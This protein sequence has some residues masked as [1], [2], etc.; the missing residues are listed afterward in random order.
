MGISVAT[1][2][3]MGVVGCVA[4][5][6]VGV[7]IARADDREN[8]VVKLVHAFQ[9]LVFSALYFCC[10]RLKKDGEV[11]TVVVK[12]CCDAMRCIGFLV[13]SRV[14]PD[15]VLQNAS[16]HEQYSNSLNACFITPAP[17]VLRPY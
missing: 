15:V 8:I 16:K 13:S 14:M 3:E 2:T 4:D 12:A 5:G 1:G 11:F 9:P 6:T 17:L 7:F 10:M